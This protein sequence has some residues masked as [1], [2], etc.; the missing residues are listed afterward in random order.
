MMDGQVAAKIAAQKSM[1]LS[2]LTM[3]GG[4]EKDGLQKGGGD[5]EKLFAEFY[6]N[7]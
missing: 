3:G 2:H 4:G 7:F 5:Q 6:A 1:A